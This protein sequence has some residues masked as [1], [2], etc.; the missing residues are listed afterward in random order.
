VIEYRV[1]N[2]RD[3]SIELT[4]TRDGVAM[5]DLVATRVQLV[6]GDA[7]L[8]SD[9]TPAY[10]NFSTPGELVLELGDAGLTAGRKSAYLVVFDAAHPDGRVFDDRLVIDVFSGI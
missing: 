10:F 9:A 8:D 6:M 4:L 3:N 5:T 2:S 7:V 1:Y